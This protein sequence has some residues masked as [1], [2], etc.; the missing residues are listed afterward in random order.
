MF[1]LIKSIFF[2]YC[3]PH[4][5]PN[6]CNLLSK[7]I[8]L[9]EA[10]NSVESVFEKFFV[11]VLLRVNLNFQQFSREL[12][13]QAALR[14]TGTASKKTCFLLYDIKVVGRGRR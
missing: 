6:Y 13:E 14:K 1:N 10:T 7:L 4:F 2:L 3:R 12:I 11:F 8:L 9:D 5:Q